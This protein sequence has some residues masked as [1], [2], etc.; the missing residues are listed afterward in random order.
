MRLGTRARTVDGSLRKHRNRDRERAVEGAAQR[1]LL[2]HRFPCGRAGSP[3]TSAA[4]SRPAGATS[5]TPTASPRAVAECDV[6]IHDAALIPPQSEK[7]PELARR[8]NVD[9]TRN[10]VAGLRSPGGEAEADLRIF[11]VRSSGHPAI[12]HHR[13]AP[14]SPFCPTDHYSRSKVECEEMIRTSGVDWGH[15]PLRR[16]APGGPFTLARQQPRDILPRRPEQSFGVPAPEGRRAGPGERRHVPGSRSPGAAH[17]RR[18]E[19]CRIRMRDLNAAYLDASGIG[20]FPLDARVHRPTQSDQ[21]RLRP[22]G[23]GVR[24]C[25]QTQPRR[26]LRRF[27]AARRRGRGRRRRRDRLSRPLAWFHFVNRTMGLI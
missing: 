5:P 19:G 17:R 27:P 9:G 26:G 13:G 24:R 21:R 14:T 7:N 23:R 18:P 16:R 3:P 2:R 25:G 22:H 10:I 20:A 15:R 12:A 4:A 1:A 8:V 6:V 11:G